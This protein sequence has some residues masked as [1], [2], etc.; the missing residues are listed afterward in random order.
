MTTDT[1]Q[2]DIGSLQSDVETM[3]RDISVV[4]SDLREVRDIMLKAQGGWKM[5][6]TLGT[7]CAFLG[8][9]ASKLIALIPIGLR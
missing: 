9:A 4:K 3:Q 5:M 2:R 6:V 1:T 7:I 8:A